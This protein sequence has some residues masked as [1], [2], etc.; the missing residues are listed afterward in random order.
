MRL[1]L[2]LCLMLLVPVAATQASSM[3]FQRFDC[4]LKTLD[5]KS[6]GASCRN[7]GLTYSFAVNEKY[8]RVIQTISL[9]GQIL[10]STPFE[11][12]TVISQDNFQ[13]ERSSQFTRKQ[14][15][16]ISSSGSYG[17]LIGD[18]AKDTRFCLKPF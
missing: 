15:I 3:K 11:K 13:C 2:P 7:S 8:Q 16:V 4:N 12:C 14:L 17:E 5:H 18:A 10:S 1:F 6:C 9:G